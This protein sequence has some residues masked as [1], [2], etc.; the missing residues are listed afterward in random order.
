MAV[1][2][3]C[4]CLA[5]TVK[6][7][8]SVLASSDHVTRYVQLS[9]TQPDGVDHDPLAAGTSTTNTQDSF[10]PVSPINVSAYRPAIGPTDIGNHL[11]T[12]I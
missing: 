7:M 4:A 11:L 1:Q 9:L 3:S 5:V 10:T 6:L 8:R 12:Y 2:W